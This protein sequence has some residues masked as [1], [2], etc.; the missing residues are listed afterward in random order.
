MRDATNRAR[1]TAPDLKELAAGLGHEFARPELLEQALTH[2]SYA[3]EL[4]AGGANNER[5]EFLGD[6]VLDLVV[7][8]RL[9]ARFPEA[10][11]GELS[12]LRAFL[13]SAP[14][15]AEIGR[16]L[17]LGDYFRLG[18]G[19]EKSGGRAKRGLLADAVEAVIAA[20][21]LDGGV[22]AAR[23]F[24]D[25]FIVGASAIAAAE[26]NLPV[27]N[28][29]SALQELVQQ[30]RLP[31]A[32]YRTTEVIGPPH[33]RTFRVEAAVADIVRTEGQGQTKK[34]AE[35]D[36][37]AKALEAVRE[38]IAQARRK[39]GYTQRM[40][41]WIFLL[42]PLMLSAEIVEKPGGPELDAS[43]Y[44]R[45]VS[46]WASP[47]QR[48]HVPSKD[49]LQIPIA[50]RKPTGGGP[51]PVLVYFHGAPGGRGM[52]KLV[53]WSRGDTGG[54]LWERFLEEG[55]VVVVADYRHPTGTGFADALASGA[56][57]YAD[58][59]ASV[60]EYVRGLPYVDAEKVVV[61]GV[62]LG[63]SVVLHMLRDVDVAGA[64]LGAGY[65]VPFLGGTIPDDAPEGDRRLRYKSMRVDQPLV[66]KNVAA[67]DT[68]LLAFVG[69]A[70]A[71]EFP[72]R[73][74]HK[75]MTAAG[76]WMRLEVY[77]DGYHDFVAGPQGHE[78]RAEPLLESTLAALESAVD[79][80][81]ERCGLE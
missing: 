46:E 58:D 69:T 45:R 42:A 39:Q 33:E 19:E 25:R 6:A 38:H 28:Y 1:E 24:A 35:Q 30:E 70:D 36:A 50:L 81:K 72:N 62:S 53:T 5:L 80:A 22:E 41:L 4:K 16:S 2:S 34:S 68:P 73:E 66:D 56:V 75:Q 32:V 67:I 63:G 48:L 31:P 43:P 61:Y 78:G 77:K 11:E 3:N 20:L 44:V 10:S 15:L 26:A 8:E 79:F 27:D 65:P 55:F 18:R 37:A 40:R 60:V 76:K 74:L 12:K 64:M 13:V 57:T 54:P 9:L 47:V 71:L 49:R 51:F 17:R 52:Q 21:Y 29:K 59:G 7:S 14:S 23:A